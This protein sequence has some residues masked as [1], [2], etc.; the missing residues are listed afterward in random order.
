[1]TLNELLDKL[2]EPKDSGCGSRQSYKHCDPGKHNNR[3]CRNKGTEDNNK[4]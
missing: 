2:V 3:D 1:M 4:C